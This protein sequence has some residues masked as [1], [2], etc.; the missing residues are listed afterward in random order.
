M[1]FLD[2][3]IDPERAHLHN[4]QG[5]ADWEQIRVGRF[6]SSEI[7][8]L[9]QFGYRPMTDKELAARP[10]KGKGS[11]TTRV[12][13]PTK[14]AD[15]AVTYINQKV[16]EV[17][18]GRPR[19]QSYAY[20]LVYGKETEPEA[21]EHFEK[22]TGLRTEV[23]GFQVYTDHAG[24]SPDRLIPEI[25]AGL[26]IKCPLEDSIMVDY[27]QLMHYNDLKAL[28]PDFYWQCVSLMLFT[29]MDSWIWGAYNP[30][31]IEDKFKFKR[32]DI[33]KDGV[34]E[35]FDLLNS[36]IEIGVAEKLKTL[37][38]LDVIANPLTQ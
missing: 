29:G 18:T 2:E 28:Y 22:M 14:L 37:K 10:K 32:I 19:H 6:T 24:G 23:V 26:E 15:K 38:M 17:L 31:M 33:P 9:L 30:R 12:P 11:Q 16:A 7:W 21:V 3:M 35:D 20:P 4:Q 1:N 36:A 25:K 34:Q 8:K 13:D 27:L 5:S